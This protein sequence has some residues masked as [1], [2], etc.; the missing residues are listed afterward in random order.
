[1]IPLIDRLEGTLSVVEE[2]VRATSPRHYIC[3][4][5]LC[6]TWN[7]ENCRLIIH[8]VNDSTAPHMQL[9]GSGGRPR[10]I[11]NVELVELLRGCGYTEIADAM[12][13]SRATIWS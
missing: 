2:G 8:G 1:M 13:M 6:S 12:Q 9:S 11:V 5:T 4:R 10:I 7:A 3:S